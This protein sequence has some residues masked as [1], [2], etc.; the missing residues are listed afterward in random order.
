MLDSLRRK[1]TR[2]ATSGTPQSPYQR[3]QQALSPAPSP[4]QPATPGAAASHASA[5]PHADALLDATSSDTRIT[6][7]V[8]NAPVSQAVVSTDANEDTV[9]RLI[10]GPD[11]NLKGAEITDC[12]TLVVEGRVEASMDSRVIQIAAIGTFV[13]TAGVDTADIRGHFDGEL[14]VRKQL[15]IR[16]TGRVTGKIR[17]GKVSI[18]EGGEL[19]G[20]IGAIGSANSGSAAGSAPGSAAGSGMGPMPSTG[21]GR[22]ASHADGAARHPGSAPRTS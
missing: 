16:S 10:V 11:I 19:S 6:S 14:T 7:S 13:G 9:S 15:I 17:Y 12:D 5:T 4:A 8:I 2:P 21:N 18:E 22:I 1:D 3:M 20:E